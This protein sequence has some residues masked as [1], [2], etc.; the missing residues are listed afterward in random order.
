MEAQAKLIE[1]MEEDLEEERK[2]GEDRGKEVSSAIDPLVLPKCNLTWLGRALVHR[3]TL[4]SPSLLHRCKIE[5]EKTIRELSKKVERLESKL[6]I[7]LI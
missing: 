4:L 6:Q 3:L 2:L 1:E 7:K 5:Q